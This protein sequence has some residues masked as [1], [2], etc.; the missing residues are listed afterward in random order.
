MKKETLGTLLA[1]IAAFVS[2]IAIPAN[3]IF[4]VNIE[5]LVFT[6]VRSVIIGTVF[7]LLSWWLF[8]SKAK[9]RQ[10]FISV[11]WKYLAAI[12]VIGGSAAFFLY[13]TGLKLT[14]AGHAAFLHKTLPLY[15][16]L[17]AFF[18]LRE[19]ITKK[20]LAATSLMF[21]GTVAIYF[22][23]I[24]P[25][26]LWLNPQLGDMLVILATLLWAAE[27]VIAKKAM[28]KG[29]TNFIVSFA[30]MFFGGLIL[31]GAALLMN[32]TDTLLALTNAQILNIGMSTLLLF[33]Y[34]LF[35][36]C[37]L[38]LINVS[39]AA[40]LL[41]LAPV[42]SLAIGAAFL[43]EPTPPVQLAGSAVILIGAYLA[44][45]IKSEQRGI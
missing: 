26:E 3:K 5:P 18:F 7:L 13:F 33:S 38:K 39:K 36:Y 28:V 32:K 44:A 34:V 22:S 27:N 11:S 2:G 8:K 29:E 31:F 35:Y 20:Y 37:S 6:A 30:R 12:A 41:L 9:K 21:A 1:A 19:R 23:S 14:T 42:V 15:T 10:R 17:L 4:I 25:S 40:V 16:A 24:V 43:G 45:G